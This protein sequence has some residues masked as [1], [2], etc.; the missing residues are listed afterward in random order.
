MC[1]DPM[2]GYVINNYFSKRCDK[3]WQN[4]IKNYGVP[5]KSVNNR[6]TI[7]EQKHDKIMN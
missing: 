5:I 2:R 7:C 3:Q 1:I 6:E 4:D